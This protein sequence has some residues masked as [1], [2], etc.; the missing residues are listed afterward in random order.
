MSSDV[1]SARVTATGTLVGQ[2]CRILGIH[3][4]DT[5]TA[6]TI[7]FRDGGAG[8]TTVCT[9]DTSAS[10]ANVEHIDVPGRGLR[11]KTDCH[12]TLSNVAAVSVFYEEG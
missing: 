8:G 1:K 4:A 5:A 7:V 10:A 3:L 9:L 2:G 11:F 12:V 6:G